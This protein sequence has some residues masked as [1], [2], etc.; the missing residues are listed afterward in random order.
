M[1]PIH[2]RVSH[3]SAAHIL[4]GTLT[5]GSSAKKRT[6][7]SLSH[8]RRHRSLRFDE[9]A[10]EVSTISSVSGR[11]R[12]CR[13]TGRGGVTLCWLGT[14]RI[15]EVS[16]LLQEF[17]GNVVNLPRFVVRHVML[18]LLLLFARVRHPVDSVE[19]RST[20]CGRRKQWRSFGLRIRHVRKSLCVTGSARG[21]TARQ[22]IETLALLQLSVSFVGALRRRVRHHVILGGIS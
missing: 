17:F 18:L 16:S 14:K 21:V 11:R 8:C 9:I 22:R 13:R 15:G 6:G 12:S 2:V 10:V 4:S 7:R 5:T 1:Q 19:H 3:P 20:G